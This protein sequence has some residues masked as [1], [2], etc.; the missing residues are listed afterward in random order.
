VPAIAA[1]MASQVP[2]AD[3]SLNRRH[4][5]DH[6]PNSAG[7]SRHG[8]PVRNRQQIPSIAVRW[9]FHGRPPFG[10]DLGINGSIRAHISSLN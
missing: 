4:R 9:S 10:P 7:T 6:E 1:K 5:L 2:S 8:D 3:Q